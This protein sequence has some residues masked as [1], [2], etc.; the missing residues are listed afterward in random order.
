MKTWI[1]VFG[2]VAVQNAFAGSCETRERFRGPN[3]PFGMTFWESAPA[4]DGSLQACVDSAAATLGSNIDCDSNQDYPQGCEVY[5]AD[6]KFVSDQGLI[7]KG[8]VRK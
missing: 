8:T 4:G 2:L 5:A 7:T 1:F 3:V 6:Y